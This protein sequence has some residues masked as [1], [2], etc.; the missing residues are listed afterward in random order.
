[1]IGAANEGPDDDVVSDAADAANDAANDADDAADD[2][3]DASDDADDAA[4]DAGTRTLLLAW[5]PALSQIPI[6]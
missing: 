5:R 6:I 2:A 4:D 1:M 3:D